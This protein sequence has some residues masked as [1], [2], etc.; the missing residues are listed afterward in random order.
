MYHLFAFLL[1]LAKASG[2]GSFQFTDTHVIVS[3][4]AFSQAIFG[5]ARTGQNGD[6][7]I[8]TCLIVNASAADDIVDG[9][10]QNAEFRPGVN[11]GSCS[12][13]VLDDDIPE[14]NET[15]TVELILNG[16]GSVVSPSVAYLTILANDHAFGIIGFN[17][18]GPIVVAE[19]TASHGGTRDIRLSRK[20]GLFGRVQVSWRITSGPNLGAD[21][22]T[23]TS[24]VVTFEEGQSLANLPIIV[25]ADNVPENDETFTLTL[26]SPTGGSEIEVN[27]D[28]ITI[29]IPANDAPIEFPL[30]HILVSENQSTVEI[31][32]Y[33]G[34]DSDGI[35]TI[36]PISEPAT[37]DWYLEAGSA[38]PGSDYVDS[39]GTL[40]FKSSETVKN[41][42]VA[43][44]ND[45][46]PELEENFTIHLVNASQ[47]AY[48]KPPGIAMVILRPNDD[49]HGVIAFGQHPHILDEDGQRTGMFYVNRSAGRFGD[50]SVSWKIMGNGADSVFET[51][52][53]R[54]TF[55]QDE[56][57]KAF[58][59]TVRQDSTPEETKEFSVL[60]YNVT[61]GGRL[62]NMA[63]SQ[64]AVFFVRDS[65]DVYGIV[66]FAPG[67]QQRINMDSIPRQLRL[68]ITRAG[69]LVGNIAVNISVMYQLPG[70]NS[71]SNEISL[72]Y[73][74][75]VAIG[76]GVES[77]LVTVDI[78]NNGFIKLGASFKA[79]LTAVKLQSGAS[80]LTNQVVPSSP[81]LGSRS[82]IFLNITS[83]DA[84]G[85]VGFSTL[86][87]TVTIQEPSGP[88]SSFLKL[89]VKRSGTADRVV[90]H[91]NI[92][93][94]SLMFFPNDT[95]PQSG[96]VVFEE[97][98]DEVNISIEIKPDDTPEVAEVFTVNLV[99][100]SGV[101]RLQAGADKAQVTIAEN[102]NPGGTFEFK[103]NNAV[104]LQE[105]G[106]PGSFD[107]VIVRKG[108][109]LDTRWV[110]FR[111]TPSGG[112]DFYGSS[113][114][115][116][117]EPGQREKTFP[118][119]VVDDS[120]PEIDEMFELRLYST[121][122]PGQ[123]GVLGE[124]ITINVTVKEN[125][126]PYGVFGFKMANIVKTIGE[127]K[128]STQTASFE[129][130]RERGTFGTVSVTWSVTAGSGADPSLDVDPT[131]G[132]VM[133]SP[134]DTSKFININS[135]ADKIPEG[136]ESFT[137]QLNNVSNIAKLGDQSLRTA[138]L[139]V[140][141]NDDPV[142]F[143]QPTLVQV[144]EGHYANLTIRRGGD[145][146]SSISVSY[147]TLDGTAA[148]GG[149]F[150]AITAGQ[151][152]FNVREFEK[153]I[154]IWII[155][156]SVPEGV[157]TFMV[158]LTSSSGD[159]VLYGNTSATVR[160]L[161]NDGGT[162][163][164]QFASNSV[165]K[166]T[167]ESTAV[168]FTVER[169][170]ATFGEVRVYWQIFRLLSDG[171]T[172]ELPTGQEFEDVT[173]FVT[174]SSGSGS[175][176]IRLTPKDDNIA[177]LD[178]TFE[179]RLINATGIQTGEDGILSTPSSAFLVIL[180]NDDP[181]GLL[182]FS[183]GSVDIPEDFASGMEA[184]T[185]K[186]LTVLRDQG[187]WGTV[188]VAW[189]VQTTE[190]SSRI[191]D[192]AYDL[193]LLGSVM[194]GVK[195]MPGW[196]RPNTQT[197]VYCFDGANNESF[198]EA[199]G[200]TVVDSKFSV[201]LWINATKG[202]YSYVLTSLSGNTLNFAFGLNTTGSN[203]MAKFIYLTNETN[204]NFGKDIADGQWHF[205]AFTVDTDT[206]TVQFYLDGDPVGNSRAI[207]SGSI[208]SDAVYLVGKGQS[209]ES[210]F[211][212]C[213]Q[214]ITVYPQVLEKD[215][216]KEMAQPNGEL[217]P[218]NGYL[219]FEPG[220]SQRQASIRTVDDNIPEDDTS[221]IVVLYSPTGGARLNTGT[222]EF[223]LTLKVLKSDNANGLFGFSSISPIVIQES[224]NVTLP[225]ERIK[226]LFGEAT[227]YWSVYNGASSVPASGDF[228]MDNG[229]VMFSDNENEKVLVIPV[230][231]ETLPELD[232]HFTV[233]LTSVMPMDGSTATSAASL[234]S[235]Y[236]RVNVTIQQSDFPF[237]LLQ[238]MRNAPVGDVTVSPSTAQFD[239]DVRE[240]AGTLTLF[241]VRA[242][243]T[244]GNVKCQW[245]TLPGSAKSPQDYTETTGSVEFPAG[246]RTS[247][248][249][250]TIVDDNVSELSKSFSVEL[251]NT[252]GG[253][254]L[255]SV[256][257]LARVTILPSDD[258]FG[259]F[260]FAPDSLSRTINEASGST[261]LLTVQRTRGLL[262][263][264]TVY[265][266]V[267]G[268]ATPDVENTNGSV[269]LPVNVNS[270]QI[271]IRIKEDVVPELAESFL[272]TLTNVS[273]GRLAN[274]GTRSNVTISASDDPY[275]VFVF[276]LSQLAVME[277]NVTVNLT[278]TR[279]SGTQGVVRVSYHSINPSMANVRMATPN[280][281]YIP[282][283]GAVV[284]G[285]GQRNATIGLHV[286]DDVMPEAAETVMVN[287]TDVQL[288][289]GH[290][291]FPAPEN[292]PRVGVS[293]VA[294]VTIEKN[295]NAN[296]VVQLSSSA[297]SLH[298]PHSGSVV[299][300]TRAAGD[301]GTIA[302]AFEV[303][304]LSANSSDYRILSRNI[305][306]LEQQREA[307]VPMQIIHDLVPEFDENFR[308]RLTEVYGGAIL[309]SPRECV[310]TILENDY[311]YGL[312]GFDNASLSVSVQEGESSNNRVTLRVIRRFGLRGGSSV[313]WEA[314]LNGVLATDDI[315]PVQGDL[316]FAQGISSRDIEFDIKPDAIPEVLEII[317]VNL[318]SVTFRSEGT[319]S[320]DQT[321]RVARVHIE[322]S[323]A[324]HG[325]VEF[326]Q[327]SYNASE[328]ST[329][330][331]V[332]SRSFGTAGD[333]RVFYSTM[334]HIGGNRAVSNVDF[335]AAAN[336]SVEIPNGESTANITI[337]I[338]D[339]GN[340]ELGEVFDVKLVSVELIG[341]SP[342]LPPQI[343]G[344]GRAAVTIVTNDDAHGLM[345]IR[346]ANPD[347][348]S[349]GS[350]VTV[351][352]TDSLSVRLVIERLKGTIGDVTVDVTVVQNGATLNSDFVA[353]KKTFSFSNNDNASQSDIVSILGDDIPE[354]DEDFIIKLVNPT[355]GARV[356]SGLGNNVTITI[357][358]NDGVAGQVGFD[359]QSRSLV[360]KEGS[361]VSLSVNRN[362][363]AGRVTVD[364]LVTGVNASSDFIDVNGT[365]E[366]KEGET[367]TSITLTVRNDTTPE[368]HEVFVVRLSNV[369][370][371]G[372]APSGHASLI[373]GKAT[374][375]ISIGA[376][377]RPHGVIELEAGSRLVSRADEAN[378]TL[379]VS[380]LF[381]DIGALRVWYE[382]TSG[383]I[384]A[385]K[386]DESLATPGLD[387]IEGK[388]SIIIGDN[389][390]VGSIPV[391]VI[392]DN[393]PEL[394]EVFIV[395]I[396]GVE[397]VNA[398]QFNN[399]I[400]PILGSNHVSQITLSANDNPHGVF[401]FSLARVFLTES[402]DPYNITVLRGEGTFGRET[403]NYFV[404]T[405][406]VG[407]SDFSILGYSGGEQ[408]LV[409]EDGVSEQH[410][411]IN[412]TDDSL[413]EGDETLTITLTRNSGKTAIGSPKTLEVVIRANDDAYGVFT[414]DQASLTKTISEPGTGPVTEA[415]F[416]VVRSVGSYGTVVVYWEVVNASSSADLTPVK[417]NVSFN[418]GDT[419]MT[420]KVKAVLDSVPE[421]AE[422]FI[423]VL[424]ITGN[425]R[426]TSPYK[427]QLTV[428]E[429]DSPY[430]EL[431]IVSSSSMDSSVD[432]EESQG[433]VTVKV[434]RKKGDFGRIT[435]DYTTI[436]RTASSASGDVA[437]FEKLQRLKT[438]DA[439]SWHAFSAFGDQ[440]VLLA[441][442]NRTGDLPFGVNDGGMGEY[443]G[444]ALFRWQGVLVPLQVIATDGGVAWD[445]YVTGDKVYLAVANHGSDG[446]YETNSR[447]YTMDHSAKLTAIQNISTQ[448]A[449]D[450]KFFQPSGQSDVYLI[451]ANQMNN[452]GQTHIS[453]Q[454]YRWATDKFMPYNANIDNTRSASSLAA[455]T[456]AG[457]LKVAIAFFQDSA[458][459]SF[460]T[461]SPIY[462]WSSN[463]F[464]L[465]Q[466]I[467]TNGPVGVEYFE[468]LG[469]QYLVFANSKS[470]VD[471]FQWNGLRFNTSLEQSIAVSDIR[472][473]KPYIVGSNAYLVTTDSSGRLGVYMW[474][475]VTKFTLQMN[476]T[477]ADIESATP[478]VINDPVAGHTALILAA[479]SG[480]GLSPVVRPLTLSSE[481]DFIPRQGQLIFEN[482]QNELELDFTILPDSTPERDEAFAVRI[483]NASGKAV[484][485]SQKQELSINILSNDDAHGRI[486]FAP[487]SLNKVQAEL[488]DDSM[489]T[490][491]VIREYGSLGRVVALWSADGNFSLGDISPLSGELVFENGQSS[492]NISITVH[493]DTIPELAEIVY[494]RLQRLT[495]T[496][497][498]DPNRGAVINTAGATAMLLIPANDEPHGVI[499]WKNAVVISQEDGPKNVTLPVYIT[500]QSGL[501]GDVVVSYET[502]QLSSVANSDDEEIAVAGVDF[503]AMRSTVEIPVGM[504]S[505]RIDLEISHYTNTRI[506]KIFKVNLTSVALKQGSMA[507]DSPR[508]NSNFRV[509]EIVIAQPNHTLGE[510]NFDVAALV[511]PATQTIM[512]NE[513]VG[514]LNITVQRSGSQTGAVGFRFIA[515]PSLSSVYS[516]ADRADFSPVEG[517][518][519]FTPGLS[520]KVFHVNITNDDEPEL[521]EG[522]FVQISRPLGGVRI[523]PQHKVDVVIEPNDEPYGLF[524]FTKKISEDINVVQEGDTLAL[525]VRRTR[526]TF[527]DVQ[528]TWVITP[529]RGVANANSQISPMNGS[530]IFRQGVA[531]GFIMLY[532]LDDLVA[533]VGQSFTVQLVAADN[534]GII[535]SALDRATIHIPANDKVEGVVAVDP[536]TRNI[537]AGEPMGGY[538][539]LFVIR[540]LRQ[541]GQSGDASV[542]WEITLQSGGST[543]ASTF[544][545]TSGS[546]YLPSGLD[547]VLLPIQV[548]NDSI[549]EQLAMYVFRLT[550]SNVVELDPSQSAREAT[551]TVVASDDP[552][553]IIEF[554]SPSYLNISE[555]VGFVNLTVVRN[556]GSIG[557]LRV[558]Y[559]I[560]SDTATHGVDYGTFGEV[561]TFADKEDQKTIHVEIKKD[562]QPE[563]SETVKVKL[564]DVNLVSPSSVNFSVVDG[565]QLNMPPR[566]N[567]AKGEVWLVIIENDEARGIIR[568]AQSALLVREDVGTAVLELIREGGTLGV[569]EVRFSVRSGTATQGSDF[570]LSDGIVSFS[571]G[572]NSARI[573]IPI[574]DDDTPEHRE[575][576][577]VTLDSVGSG[578]KLGSPTVVTVT[579]ETSDDPNGLFGF[580]NAS[581]LLLE[582]PS[583]STDIKF[584]IE[585]DG[586][587]QGEVKVWW[588]LVRLQP[589][590]DACL[591][592]DDFEGE[593]NGSEIFPNSVIG[594][595]RT[596]KLRIRPF[597]GHDEPEEQFLLTIYQ[598]SGNAAIDGLRSNI[599]ITI[600]K[601]GFPNGVFRFQDTVNWQITGPSD[602]VKTTS[603]TVTF[604]ANEDQKNIVV[605]ITSD[606][607]PEVEKVYSLQIVSV[608]GGAD[609]DA[610]HANVTFRISANDEPHGVFK[611]QPGA[612]RVE[613]T[614]NTRQ[615]QFAVQREKGTFGTVDIQYE[616]RYSQW[617]PVE[618][619]GSVEVADKQ[620]SVFKNIPLSAFL[621]VG[622]TFT[623]ML[624]G[625]RY[626]DSQVPM[627]SISPKLSTDSPSDRSEVVPLPE[628]AAN[629]VLKF[630][631]NSLKLTVG[632]NNVVSS[633]TVLREGLFGSVSV[634]VAT[635]S[636]AGTFPAGFSA[637]QVLISGSP[638]SFTGSIRNV[639]FSAIVGPMLVPDK[640]LV[641]SM[642]LA[643]VRT[644]PADLL[645]GANI[646]TD[647]SRRT[648]VVDYS[649][650]VV[651]S[652]ASQ[653]LVAV[654]GSVVK[655]TI[656]RQFSVL[657][658]VTVNYVF[659]GQSKSLNMAEGEFSKEFNIDVT[660]SNDKPEKDRLLYL[661]LTSVT[662]SF[663][664]RLGVNKTVRITVKDNDDPRGVL[665]FRNPRVTV[666]EN[667]TSGNT[668]V[669]ELEIQR[670]KGTLGNVS[671]LVRTVGGGERWT[672]NLLSLKEAIARKTGQRNATVG[673]DYVELDF[674]VH[675][676]EADPIP[677]E[678]QVKKVQLVIN[679]D[680]TAEPD[681]V[682]LVYL[683]DA[684]GGARVASDA[685][686]RL[687]SWATVTIEGNDLMNGLIKFAS[688]TATAD[689][690]KGKP[691]VLKVERTKAFG[692]VQVQW[693]VSESAFRSEVEPSQGTIAFASGEKM[694][695][696]TIR[697][698]NDNKPERKGE[699]HVNLTKINSGS[700]ALI[701]SPSSATV[702]V[703]DSDYP[704]G[705]I[706][707]SKDAI[708]KAVDKSSTEVSVEVIR[709][710][711]LDTDII[712]YYE[713]RDLS[714]RITTKPGVETY[715]ALA[716]QDYQRPN[717]KFVRFAKQET[718][719]LIS[720]PL[721]RLEASATN[722]PK[723]F[724]IVLLNATSGA[725]IMPGLNLSM[726]IIS[727]RKETTAFLRLRALALRTPLTDDDIYG[728]LT[729]LYNSIQNTLNE[730]Q[731]QLTR[732]TITVILN[733]KRDVALADRLTSLM[734]KIFDE[735][736]NPS[737]EDTK[738]QEK[739][740]VVFEAFA[741][742]LLNGKS[743]P[744]LQGAAITGTYAVVES[745]RRT[746]EQMNGLKFNASNGKDY[747]KYPS[748]LYSSSSSSDD[749]DC[750]DVH[751]I[752]YHTAHWFKKPDQ[753][754]V[755]SDKVLSTSLRPSTSSDDFPSPVSSRNPI[756]YRIYTNNKR[757]TPKGADCVFWD[758]SKA[759]WS[760]EGC[761]SKNDKGEYVECQCDHLSVFAAQGES[762]DRT[763]YNLAFFIV[764]FVCLGVFAVAVIIHHLC[765]VINMFAAKLLTHLFFACMMGQLMFILGAFVSPNLVDEPIRCSVLAMFFHYFFLCQ[766]T[767]MFVEAWNLWRIFVLNDEHTDRK[768]VM[769]FILGWGLPV[770]AI[771][772]YIMITQL[773]FGW[774]FTIAYADVH[775]NGDMCFIPNAYA[776][777]AAAV[778]PV[779][780]LLMGVA[781]VFTQAYQVT[782]Q[783]KHYDDL[784]RGHYN[785]KEIR[786]IIMLFV[787]VTL[788][789]LFAG[790]HV[791]FGAF[792][793]LITCIVLDGILALYV[794]IW[795][796]CLRNQ[797]RGV[798]KKSFAVTSVPPPIELREDMFRDRPG[799]PAHSI[800]SLKRPVMMN[801]PD[802]PV[803]LTK[804]ER[805]ISSAGY[806]SL[807][808]SD[809]DD[810]DLGATPKGSR[811]MLVNLDDTDSLGRVN[812][813]YEDDLENQDFDD[814]IFALK[815]GGQYEG[816]PTRDEDKVPEMDSGRFGD[817]PFG[818]R[819]ISIADT[820]L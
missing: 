714:E 123:E 525:E 305:T 1:V 318:T 388:R 256:A 326:A 275:G 253:A 137:I 288:L 578:A 538:D 330:Y 603:G 328:G 616:V 211:T 632:A 481:A 649:G 30:D 633:I 300:V 365:V 493:R 727:D 534:G 729:E 785:I 87:Q 581:Q 180:A 758:Y 556:G 698:I 422:T 176:D 614:G 723:A 67:N 208:S 127:S 195:S 554:Q 274:D 374:A 434:L 648:A 395:N 463:S 153:E 5:I 558:N 146:A 347:A 791:A 143:A 6:K 262:G 689:E 203:T 710:H 638:L 713:T 619:K 309:G 282:I 162:G 657:G 29:N 461:Q 514:R 491:E 654:E 129:V 750:R 306:L 258:A 597:L 54:L 246:S 411:T 124:K 749:S 416:V 402:S 69:G 394:D 170:I 367:H 179:L 810:L 737:R 58:Q 194:E 307:S 19:P 317:D 161:A 298:E 73:P 151:V 744:G 462:E 379:T 761:T 435:L 72:T 209:S 608:D 706:Q 285:D 199:S 240:S 188:K 674:R 814:L 572:Q 255:N 277:S 291:V 226:G 250:I 726:V 224:N 735:L 157:E 24:G 158:N 356:A 792:W 740:S 757:V 647:V 414:L 717:T 213:I 760:M 412:V 454:V 733:Y 517:A 21:D 759:T 254:Q 795:Y 131:Y 156:D 530:I 302:I 221:Y 623:I 126:D 591:L 106:S 767:W 765:S 50:V 220:V 695:D 768:L 37:V 192:N 400:P 311:P 606:D 444:S 448:G 190:V 774:E 788:V 177:E 353:S 650:V 75:E 264:S 423:I 764:F 512:L 699:F 198:V 344:V 9:L 690:D 71:P 263:G 215:L 383:N 324:P 513:D 189:E 604:L 721:T 452:A 594:A 273:A 113:K 38:V 398:A 484:V 685:D 283:S 289:S 644:T 598:V 787:L 577:T 552:F 225:I 284:F 91:W 660:D 219:T 114:L 741:F 62:K 455:F 159:T 145:G 408:T 378:F 611:L 465:L 339:D 265:W 381:G 692:E 565:M 109:A 748:N 678:G 762:D 609:L 610:R 490:F 187:T 509:I 682:V 315:T 673:P 596:V 482:G 31:D 59:V 201:R 270:T 754:P 322:A 144:R 808:I 26:E 676:P 132:H 164:F 813:M 101:D 588:K 494:I 535:A 191:S 466:E 316:V 635:G 185:Q 355:G 331:L 112:D 292:S 248:I 474:D 753:S 10:A 230:N 599:T 782:P 242:Q 216:V 296:G 520:S 40:T 620:S 279:K 280:V 349:H 516:S 206:S 709:G 382:A 507:D 436:S 139:I 233:V 118:V 613:V 592:S 802:D 34:L 406:T 329:V 385:L 86:H 362:L 730:D 138:T 96:N 16:N 41:I 607:V 370:T 93:S 786:Y 415:E 359:E 11:S 769:F 196:R 805:R 501:I 100:V 716:G 724:E 350:R 97:G 561:L 502:V 522:F 629:A 368:T 688:T 816:D 360:V 803:Y 540:L 7:V 480:K 425:G 441:S 651:I 543:P 380:R 807:T 811:K 736:L 523:G 286:L 656:L 595:E 560:S 130:S 387:F 662:G 338:Y 590:C 121:G 77:V 247:T 798:F 539:G 261:V 90:V 401:K 116:K 776:A 323:D 483:Y 366:F 165:N 172:S 80:A 664:P 160:I 712:V 670:T 665:S 42:T 358:A 410:I 680:G 266:Q 430:G 686:I 653:N 66:N 52:S 236:T 819:R 3:E 110:S 426:L 214:D 801:S 183:V 542:D 310:V 711:G 396:T 510:I 89:P 815:T 817:D 79:E 447:I 427:A 98:H 303:D 166:T 369:Q 27:A 409:F 105:S 738:G 420:F 149:D 352:E 15:F 631:D 584:I 20:A 171:S 175:Q 431:Q 704:D 343:G 68:N 197:Y 696:L 722:Y 571:D 152:T 731:M 799:S 104:E 471:I 627:T 304:A 18:T 102:D 276:A 544:N 294:R 694:K 405:Q 299:N 243:G 267:S 35:T 646:T 755:I 702:M 663:F 438:L 553:G 747:F 141:K 336:S 697:L 548:K 728:I 439:Y 140:T 351:D 489:V 287:L 13:T 32:I 691:A 812:E 683:T 312:I 583:I 217:S 681:E 720:I 658:S 777:L 600:S 108:S 84:N 293:R 625:V 497:S 134:G 147:Q 628:N 557:E 56:S 668:R 684:R 348:N 154:S 218:I 505:T 325:V 269:V 64:R 743:C 766:F 44:L 495:E 397:L 449:S 569:A 204:I 641:Y 48:I 239:V 532:A 345:V 148:A 586:G 458:S 630:A 45:N 746:P 809:W 451:V 677:D 700:Q 186:N 235:G 450:V 413:P 229:S 321:T 515:Q 440:F 708:Y 39:R 499:A 549:A 337:D 111:M 511:D 576:F 679:D 28:E 793:M 652:P 268:Q 403:V 168:V 95:G 342:V 574:I 341:H 818:L 17:E 703:L 615:L 529:G 775:N 575:T 308:I 745:F 135:V 672:S 634:N 76:T 640:K 559:N 527:R 333:I 244:L 83:K 563:L 327:A 537:I 579:I 624:T 257:N 389:V 784:F 81:R 43:L 707:F 568:F 361:Q 82:A 453:S 771:V 205:I 645:G 667:A 390:D 234:R 669:V 661:N 228:I 49:Q 375:T 536:S 319:P 4:T 734:M 272:V 820:H 25:K 528:V 585:R 421:K 386:S 314:R 566:I 376:N 470:T 675:F 477:I 428:T 562:E 107:V 384:T 193:F 796:C 94:D 467:R 173:G 407:P 473:A 14:H 115:D 701:V 155:N 88:S 637:G 671:V 593:T 445:S 772:L 472:S 725:K 496:G 419:R 55:L 238:F 65:D 57:L 136:N 533:E 46:E 51:T 222:S 297:V 433:I 92:T 783:W 779:L 518:V 460:Q 573:N 61:G 655:C 752:N 479:V 278:V 478:F 636:L 429:N 626:S 335:L 443:L 332:V 457:S 372:I 122:P 232:E 541:V 642:Y 551:I 643:S 524:G 545:V 354:P 237:G 437:H 346:A 794:L 120:V 8:A 249:N 99:N 128:S 184:S 391:W 781:V 570:I 133:F 163:T 33:R 174:F 687:Q 564:L 666:P 245:K 70:S 399:T 417:G 442:K 207:P 622:S 751:F 212:G 546:V 142:Y 531:S 715:Q 617:Y 486:G 259:V 789:W 618:M 492:Q 468:F 252:E 500:R 739:F 60:L 732:D 231:D 503:K 464:T 392:D 659:L 550:R 22:F 63:S 125:D 506:T 393:F 85:E 202:N 373:H 223:K 103:D 508:I 763:G 770:L 519:M 589:S 580:V 800:G 260:S 485:D 605:E 23:H 119:I 320:L 719:K 364:W 313:H 780:L 424:N 251:F 53:G 582:N 182:Q 150:L 693:I 340:P 301:F 371:F 567:S 178:E 804:L 418:D 778:G 773:G 790:L 78:G 36:G 167:T 475:S 555:D 498:A 488:A 74:P 181:N 602:G 526:G 459:G 456:N 169:N 806:P 281:D 469:N 334:E 521:E 200:L 271:A 363:S 290:P 639:T 756:T 357:R 705:T 2:Q 476:T 621:H 797:L 446:R 227:V 742:S 210:G 718:S 487:S 587:A 241:V 117:F 432:I 504:N 547:T 601:H 47:N 295:D 377:D 404:V 12:F 612:Q